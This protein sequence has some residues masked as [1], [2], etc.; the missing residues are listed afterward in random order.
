MAVVPFFVPPSP[1]PRLTPPRL[2]C[3]PSCR[4]ASRADCFPRSRSAAHDTTF[5]VHLQQD[6]TS[7]MADRFHLRQVFPYIPIR[8]KAGIS[9]SHHDESRFPP[10]A[11]YMRH[12]ER[13]EIAAVCFPPLTHLAV[14][15]PLALPIRRDK[16][17]LRI[18][19]VGRISRLPCPIAMLLY[20]YTE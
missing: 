6:D 5:S 11:L 9:I 1:S 13:G 20:K 7:R 19:R 12:G 4:R 10:H 3:R 18:F 15:P 8:R 17:D 16:P 14:R 2:P